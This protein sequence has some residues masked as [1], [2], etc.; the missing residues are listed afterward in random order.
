MERSRRVELLSP[1]GNEEGFY[2]AI[3]AGADAVYLAGNRFGARA[4]ADNFTTESLV[5]CIRY[6]HL[7]GRRIYL[8]VNTLLKEEEISQLYDYLLPFYEA[9]LDAVIVQDLGVLRFVREH[10]PKLKIH[11]S[12]QMTLCG[13]YGAALLKRMGAERI[14]PARE[15]GLQELAVMKQRADIE[16]EA[17]IH[18]AMCYCYSGQCLFSSIL[19]GRSGNR[20]RC[21]QPCRLPYSVSAGNRKEKECYPLSLK[22]MCTIEHLPTLMEAGIDSFKIE[23]RMKKPEYTA[24][25]T[26]IYRRYIDLY[27]R[28]K[29]ER[30]AEEAASAYHVDRA[31]LEQ[32]RS[33]YIRSGIQ[34]GYYFRR[35]G[36][37]MITLESPAYSGSN[38]KL[39]ADIRGTHLHVREKL[40]VSVKAVFRVGLP[41]E[42]TYTW[43]D[44]SFRATG[45]M[46]ERA[47]KQPITPE[48]IRKQLGKLGDSAF[49]TA[50]ADMD[51][52]AD[53]DSFY[54]LKQINEL[55]RTA[56]AGLEEQILSF[57]GYLADADLDG[58][59]TGGLAEEQRGKNA[60]KEQ[61]GTN[62]VSREM[63]AGQRCL[64]FSVCTIH[65]LKAV[66]DW[67]SGEKADRPL[68]FYI[69]GDLFLSERQ[70]VLDICN[71]MPAE[72]SFYLA[73]PYILRESDRSYLEALSSAMRESGIFRGFLVRS[74]DGLGYVR[75][76]M[77]GELS[78]EEENLHCR[79]DAGVYAWN[80]WAV[81]ELASYADGFCLPY[82]LKGS[83]QKGLPDGLPCEKIVYGRIPMMITANCLFRTF[84]E[85]RKNEDAVSEA[86]LQGN[87][88][89]SRKYKDNAEYFQVP[90]DK[91]DNKVG[92]KSVGAEKR[93][94][95]GLENENCRMPGEHA[96]SGYHHAILKDRYRREFP[97]V[98][99]CL[100]CMN[101]IYNTVPLSLHQMI[102]KWEG[103]VDLRMDFTLESGDEV[104]ALLDAFWKGAPLPLKE[105]TTGHEKRGVE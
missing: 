65:Q 34:D 95:V 14:V 36:R 86:K 103:R 31:D 97:V 12:T 81:R 91:R 42:V 71:R 73:L 47:G 63:C 43:A 30:G 26:A 33:L 69:E 82:E 18:G 52:V 83:E 60:E 23:G 104:R 37:E 93:S 59:K 38:E 15:L 53:E 19:G 11:V 17:F 48:N 90:L 49:R 7:L 56:I 50:E 3:H 55:R 5:A 66:A 87:D 46:V 74:M 16:I 79:T 45:D 58:F 35:N 75:E 2:G 1:A 78:M 76:L 64:V 24:G 27:G 61:Y 100:H 21:A 4:Y 13:S 89:R 6:A 40:P 88:R 22:D 39:L 57:R 92:R 8:T 32:L 9:G 51:I 25:V 85:C 99:N 101:T 28:L 77:E 20:G 67:F 105:Y 68:R 96:G 44:R 102:S 62:P 84:R 70:E 98:T 10:F 54:P 72:S 94:H 29:E 41:A 80:Q